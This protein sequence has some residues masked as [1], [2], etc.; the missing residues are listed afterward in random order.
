LLLLA[1]TPPGIA[2]GISMGGC[3]HIDIRSFF[4]SMLTES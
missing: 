1:P 2:C 3:R 4:D